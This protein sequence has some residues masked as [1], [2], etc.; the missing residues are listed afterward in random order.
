MKLPLLTT[1][2]SLLSISGSVSLSYAAIP[3]ATLSSPAATSLSQQGRDPAEFPGYVEQ[4]KATARQ[5]GFSDATIATAFAGIH[6][7]D[8]AIKSDRS[9]L[10]HKV[11]LNDYLS[12]VLTLGK[13]EKGREKLNEYRASLDR[14]ASQS[15]VSPEYIVALWAMESQFGTIQGK[16]DVISALATLAF[17]GRREAFFTKELMAALKIIQQQG[18]T[19]DSLKGSWA[20]AMGQSQFMP[21]SFLN[22]GRDGDGDGKIDIWNNVDDVFASIASYLQK[23]GWKAG[24]GWGSEVTLPPGFDNRLNGLKTAQAKTL[25]QWQQLGV[26]VKTPAQGNAPGRAW[27]VTPEDGDGR[28]FMVY[29]NFRTLMHWNRSYYFAISIG[30]MADA[31]AQ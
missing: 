28:S 22:Y 21:S 19:A 4:L 11:T 10:E 5:Q 6:F 13:I 15:G 26:V 31:L 12:R 25:A 1:L 23:E 8:R 3:S 9:Q 24:Q 14:V 30:M 29:D 27:I 16:E 7:V 20:G 2:L 17:E 18:M